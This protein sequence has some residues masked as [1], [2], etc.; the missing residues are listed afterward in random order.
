MGFI[1]FSCRVLFSSIFIL[2]AWQKI[3]DFGVDGGGETTSMQP[4]FGL[5]KNHVTTL[6][7]PEVEIYNECEIKIH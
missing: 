5:F 3:N 1:S 4:N 6:H 7:V 2:A